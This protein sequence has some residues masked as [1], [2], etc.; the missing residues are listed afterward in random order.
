[1]ALLMTGCPSPGGGDTT[2]TGGSG[3]GTAGKPGGEGGG[4]KPPGGGGAKP[5]G[6]T[7]PP[8][9]GGVS[10]PAVFTTT[11]TGSIQDKAFG[12]GL[13]GVK[14]SALIT[15]VNSENKPAVSDSDGKFTLQVK[16]SGTFKLA[17]ESTCYNSF[18]TADI[19]A[20]AD[21]SHDAG[22]IGLTAKPEPTGAARY[23]FTPK[24]PA[25]DK[26]F[27]LTVNCV[28][29]ISNDEF[30]GVIATGIIRAKAADEGLTIAAD[31]RTM[32]TE[33]SLP[34][35]LTKIG[36]RGL[37]GHNLIPAL[38]I[39]NNVETIGNN[40][41]SSFGASIIPPGVI[42]SFESS[43][44]LRSVGDNAFGG[45]RLRDFSL[46]ENLETIGQRAFHIADFRFSPTVPKT[47]I[48]PA[49]AAKIGNEA[50]AA[51]SAHV[52]GI[53]EV[54]IL[55]EKL[56]KTGSGPFP[57]GNNLFQNASSGITEIRLPQAVFDSYTAT[58][59]SAIFGTALTPLLKPQ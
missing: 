42:I 29:E 27:K 15:P 31:A 50:F 18:T 25:A 49:N 10:Q 1:M 13:S 53:T 57:L 14:V 59:L 37:L 8:P 45:S 26:K 43:S 22:A 2:P 7:T 35:T 52:L 36:D 4:T 24:G 17:M 12:S 16:H 34:R 46:P 44:R 19:S 9:G 30:N 3:G 33:I 38:T 48:I 21:G 55:S 28:R 39:P 51:L 58:E 6:T 54:E 47:I 5:P 40:A 56:A 32:V 41:F 20:S 23:T 11:V